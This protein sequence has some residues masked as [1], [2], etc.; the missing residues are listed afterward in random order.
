MVGDGS[1]DLGFEVIC[2]ADRAI[3]EECDEVI[4]RKGKMYGAVDVDAFCN[5]DGDIRIDSFVEAY[6][7][8]L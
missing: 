2:R 5:E 7:E 1:V 8:A 4:Q 6:A 3:P